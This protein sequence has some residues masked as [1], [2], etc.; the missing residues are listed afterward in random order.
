[1]YE[2]E[3]IKDENKFFFLYVVF[4]MKETGREKGGREGELYYVMK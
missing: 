3:T 2:L 4:G 1:M